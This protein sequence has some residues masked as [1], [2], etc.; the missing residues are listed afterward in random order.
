M[1]GGKDRKT[2]ADADPNNQ[3][4]SQRW[5]QDSGDVKA[6]GVKR[7]GIHQML[8]GHQLPEN[9]LRCRRVYG[10]DRP[11]KNFEPEQVPE[12][13]NSQGIKGEENKRRHGREKLHQ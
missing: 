4:A 9:R 8:A 7:D 11:E 10:A 13:E 2:T 12:L 3:N 5:T 1:A 6:D